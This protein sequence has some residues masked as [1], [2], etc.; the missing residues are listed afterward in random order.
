MTFTQLKTHTVTNFP[1]TVRKFHLIRLRLSPQPC[2][3]I[4]VTVRDEIRNR[5]E[6]NS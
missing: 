4:F 1:V 5:M 3:K 2:G 6:K